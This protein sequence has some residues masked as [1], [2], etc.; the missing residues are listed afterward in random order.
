MALSGWTMYGR[1]VADA[2]ARR[3]RCRPKPL[4]AIG[5]T[6]D[7]RH[8]GFAIQ[9]LT[10]PGD[11]VLRRFD[12]AA[13][14]DLGLARI[15]AKGYTDNVW[16]SWT[17]KPEAALLLHPGGPKQSPAGQMRRWSPLSLQSRG[18]RREAI[19]KAL[20]RP[21]APVDIFQQEQHLQISARPYFRRRPMRLSP[22]ASAQRN[23]L[24]LIGGLAARMRGTAFA[25]HL[26]M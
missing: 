16:F 4:A 2:L 14:P 6:E 10:A 23:T 24:F 12:P 17:G 26:S 8:S 1:M 18:K 21:S 7:Q 3:A 5:C 9:F 15:R 19:H 22:R 11:E 13:A 25:E 20:G